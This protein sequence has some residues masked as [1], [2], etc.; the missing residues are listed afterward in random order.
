MSAQMFVRCSDGTGIEGHIM[1]NFRCEREAKLKL[2]FTDDTM[3]PYDDIYVLYG[4]CPALQISENEVA[5][6]D[7]INV[8]Y[9]FLYG[10]TVKELMRPKNSGEMFDL[11]NNY[12]Y[13]PREWTK[14]MVESM[15][16]ELFCLA[17]YAFLSS[18]SNFESKAWKILKFVLAVLK[19]SPGTLQLLL[20][21]AGRQYDVYS[22]S[23]FW[24]VI[25]DGLQSRTLDY[26]SES[27]SYDAF[28]A[29][30][31]IEP[32][33][34]EENYKNLKTECM[35]F[36]DA[37]AKK[38]IDEAC[39]QTYTAREIIN[40]NIETLFF[41]NEYFKK[42]S[43]TG[44]TEQYVMST[45]FEFLSYMGDEVAS[46]CEMQDADA[47]YAKALKYAQN[48]E[49]IDSITNRRGKIS[50][51]VAAEEEEQ[52][53]IQCEMERKQEKEAK[54]DDL[55]EKLVPV[56]GVSY[57]VGVV[58]DLLF[59]ILTFLNIFNPAS[60][61]IFI[62]SLCITVPFSIIFLIEEIKQRRSRGK[63]KYFQ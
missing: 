43:S 3:P 32:F 55:M 49:E 29:M 18:K 13:E 26:L 56:L 45:F 23:N 44:T 25:S 5:N 41:Y 50:P 12:I 51:L 19:E 35:E 38:R 17:Y 48:N 15:N 39:R 34:P 60:K 57:L 6:A 28:Q 46:V 24:T 53:K 36:F 16:W 1:F 31:E 40:L 22:C 54:K 59:G 62:V 33:I 8:V 42:F 11:S 10:H 27:T 37:L 20:S 61:I 63:I 58:A 4:V 9:N 52:K 30:N 2:E 47:I 21:R 7:S 14:E